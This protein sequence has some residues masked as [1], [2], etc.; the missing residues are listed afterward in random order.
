M[1][2][3]WGVRGLY[4]ARGVESCAFCFRICPLMI[5]LLDFWLPDLPRVEDLEVL[6]FRGLGFGISGFR[7]QRVFRNQ[8]LC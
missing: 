3:V 8:G 7:V 5:Q 2:R 4:R 6:G 1:T